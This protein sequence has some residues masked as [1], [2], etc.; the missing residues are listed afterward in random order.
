MPDISLKDQIACARRELAIRDK[1]YPRR[2][3]TG[4]MTEAAMKKELAAMAAIIDTLEKLK[5]QEDGTP[6]EAPPF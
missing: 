4:D 5:R 2:V 6:D 1:V 3:Q